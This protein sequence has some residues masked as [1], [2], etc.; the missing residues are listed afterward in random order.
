MAGSHHIQSNSTA[1]SQADGWKL[2]LYQSTF[3]VA[4]IPFDVRVKLLVVQIFWRLRPTVR[5]PFP[6]KV[7]R[8]LNPENL[9]RYFES[10]RTIDRE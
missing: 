3:V 4:M 7:I 8:A 1:F 10:M 5:E 9:A 6:P 2:G